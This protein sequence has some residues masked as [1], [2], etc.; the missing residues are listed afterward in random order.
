MAQIGNFDANQVEPAVDQLPVGWYI[1]QI[2]ASE[3]KNNRTTQGQHLSLEFNITDGQF[4]GWKLWEQL[5]LW[6]QNQQAS[7]IAQ[8]RLSAIARAINVLQFND[9]TS[10]HGFNMQV[11][12]A[13]NSEGKAEIKGY[14]ALEVEGHQASPGRA[15]AE[16]NMTAAQQQSPANP[17][18]NPATNQ[19]YTPAEMQQINQQR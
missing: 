1:A 4:K 8:G 7:Q 2:V 19:P 15:Y 11:R 13:H 5:N 17:N 16:N 10:L 3:V 6:H 9:T 14:K 18:I 12:V